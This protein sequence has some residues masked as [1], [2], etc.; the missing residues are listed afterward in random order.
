MKFQIIRLPLLCTFVSADFSQKV[1]YHNIEKGSFLCLLSQKDLKVEDCEIFLGTEDGFVYANIASDASSR[2]T[3]AWAAQLDTYHELGL[4]YSIKWE[5]YW[6]HRHTIKQKFELNRKIQGYV[7]INL[8]NSIKIWISEN[9]LTFFN[10]H[11]A[12]A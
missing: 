2:L 9:D 1:Q 3:L 7:A 11:F 5:E 4:D 6:N 12:C 8:N 10:K